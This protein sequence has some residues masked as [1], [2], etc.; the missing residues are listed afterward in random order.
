MDQ[1]FEDG[2]GR[3]WL[4]QGMNYSLFDPVTERTIRNPAKQ[5]AE[6]GVVGGIDRFYIDSNSG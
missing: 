2:A 1:I 6:Y 3:L 5:L 4:R